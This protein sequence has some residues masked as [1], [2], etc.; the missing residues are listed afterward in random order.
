[1]P[2]AAATAARCSEL[3]EWV[4]LDTIGYIGPYDNCVTRAEGV[5][6]VGWRIQVSL[7]IAEPPIFSTFFVHFPDLRSIDSRVSACVT[8]VD[9]GVLLIR[10]AFPDPDC[11]HMMDSNVFIYSV[12]PGTSSPL[13]SAEPQPHWPP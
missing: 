11:E 4:F 8:G 9:A 12:A 3:P 6:S 13:P 7:V 10:L 2:E 5:T 1:M